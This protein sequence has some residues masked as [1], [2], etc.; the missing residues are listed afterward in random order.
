MQVRVLIVLGL[1][2]AIERRARG[3]VCT[4]LWDIEGC[5]VGLGWAG[6]LCGKGDRSK[7]VTSTHV[8]SVSTTRIRVFGCNRVRAI[9]RGAT[10]AASRPRTARQSRRSTI[11]RS[12][13][14]RKSASRFSRASTRRGCHCMLYRWMCRVWVSRVD[15]QNEARC[16]IDIVPRMAL[17]SASAVR[18]RCALPSRCETV[19]RDSSERTACGYASRPITGWLCVCVS[20]LARYQRDTLMRT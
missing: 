6:C 5:A 1:E 13:E 7:V 14:R 3:R 4:E 17:L 15:K 10:T 11:E 18:S 16:T 20:S 2:G 9:A 12:H 19:Q 8:R